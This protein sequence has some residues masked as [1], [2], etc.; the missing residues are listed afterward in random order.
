[1][2]TLRDHAGEEMLAFCQELIRIPSPT[3][4]EKA[5]AELIAS[6]MRRLGYD[7]VR[8]D[9]AGNVIGTIRATDPDLPSVMFTAHMDQVSPGERSRWDYDPYGGERDGGWIHGRGASDTK[10][11]IATQV[12]LPTAIADRVERHGDL[13]VAQV[14]I[15]EVAGLGSRVLLDHLRPD[16]AI[17]GEATSNEL[18]N[19]NRGR[20]LA[21]ARFHGE[22][23]HASIA[24]RDQIAHYKAAA[25]LLAL[26]DLPMRQGLMGGSSAVPTRC[27]TDLPDDNVTPHLCELSIDWR[28]IPGEHPE[29]VLERLREILPPGGDVEIPP[30]DLETYTG[31]SYRL[32]YPQPAHWVAPDD[33]F[34]IASQGALRAHWGREVPVA[35]WGFTTD[36]GLFTERGIPI[37][38]F[39]PCEEI[40]AHT[41]R[42]RVSVALMLEAWDAYPVLVEAISGLPRRGQ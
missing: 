16:Y 4:D 26:A 22:S 30:F 14:V 6:E 25:F 27:S 34:V 28:L 3:G 7:E 31:R 35:P 12:H 38:G 37:L 8:F 24:R 42:D 32:E 17:M 29:E 11:A 19:G 33:P 41:P 21:R 23:V 13:H 5:L 40:Y 20:I 1:M 39:S 15:E 2:T 36:C 18:R 9:E 10:G